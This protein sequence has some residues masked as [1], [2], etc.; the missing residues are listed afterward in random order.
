MNS[1]A[2]NINKVVDNGS[3]INTWL[4]VLWNRL[5]SE[6]SLIDNYSHSQGLLSTQLYLNFLESLNLLDRKN[7]PV[8][9]RERWKSIVLK[10]KDKNKAK[11]TA[12]RLGT[13]YTIKVGDQDSSLFGRTTKL[14][15]G[16]FASISG[17]SAYPLPK[18]INNIIGTITDSIINPTHIYV[19][20]IDFEVRDETIIFLNDK[21][22]F[23]KGFPKRS[24]SD[25]EEVHI[26]CTDVLY[27]KNY[28]YDF[29]GYVLGIR[30]PSSEFYAKYLNGLWDL[31]NS[32]API[33]LVQAGIASILGEPW[34]LDKEETVEHII[35]ENDNFQVITDKHVYSLTNGSV[36]RKKIVLGARLNFGEFLTETL[37]T[38][39]NLDPVRI[40]ADSEYWQRLKK[41]VNALF[42]PSSFFRAE[43]K[44]GLSFTW[45]KVPLLY[46]GKDANGN[47]KLKFKIYGTSSDVDIFWNDFWDYLEFTGTKGT[48]CFS[49]EI[50]GTL[51]ETLGATWG[52]ISPLEYFLSS[53]LKSNLMILVVDSNR[54]TTFGRRNMSRLI[55]LKDVIPAHIS[56]LV[57]ERVD[58]PTNEYDMTYTTT[59]NFTQRLV[60]QFYELAGPYQYVKSKLTYGDTRPIVHLIPKCG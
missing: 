33:S 31:H 30:E 43:I 50:H 6:R 41:D 17:M 12:L 13:D 16:G 32:G 44:Q 8:L 56:L 55:R 19:Q 36:L 47:P 4:G 20:G 28:V 26:W 2:A 51:L 9:H 25:G 21:D 45:D 3:L 23:I 27:D 39:S 18:D 60:K 24:S 54:L 48:T 11:A 53:F 7:A 5:F 52:S 34:V 37:R 29:I 59:D 38:Y 22:P 49:S 35:N 57:M 40:S 15:I 42:L 10:S 58:I 46:Q 14:S 1:I